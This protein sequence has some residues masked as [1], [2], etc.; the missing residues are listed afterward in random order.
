MSRSIKKRL[1]IDNDLDIETRF[2]QLEN[3]HLSHKSIEDFDQYTSLQSEND[4]Y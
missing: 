1:S 4:C 3:D 2:E